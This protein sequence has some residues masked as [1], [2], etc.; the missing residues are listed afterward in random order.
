[1][2]IAAGG[3]GGADGSVDTSKGRVELALGA[4]PA[5]GDEGAMRGVGCFA[6]ILSVP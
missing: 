2:E 3:G 1:V 5:L 4:F 6:G